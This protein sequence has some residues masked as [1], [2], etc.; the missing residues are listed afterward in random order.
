MP[1]HLPEGLMVSVSGVRG[2][3]G[4]PLTPELVCAVAAAFGA[5]L[6]GHES[7]RAICIGRDSRVSGPMFMRAVTA[8][9]QSVGCD[10]IELGVVPTPTLLL[11]VRHHGAIGGIGVT[12]S[13]NP[14]EWNA[15]KLI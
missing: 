2:R 13:H 14:A 11:A 10:V 15:L 3:V 6:R 7:G 4:D 1:I 5:H 8:G 12:A 9:L